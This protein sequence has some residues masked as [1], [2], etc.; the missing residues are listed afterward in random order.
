L[1]NRLSQQAFRKRQNA[2]IKDLERRLQIRGTTD[3]EQIAQLERDNRALREQ[4]TA[5]VNKLE[6][7]QS[8]LRSLSDAM[9]SLVCDQGSRKP[10]LEGELQRPSSPDQKPNCN[11]TYQPVSTTPNITD[12]LGL[13]V[14]HGADLQPQMDD[15]ASLLPTFQL[16]SESGLF[17]EDAGVPL[18]EN[19]WTDVERKWIAQPPRGSSMSVSSPGDCLGRNI[20]SPFTK[21]MDLTSLPGVWTHQYQ[22]G[23]PVFRAHK[24]TLEES[25][26]AFTNSNSSFSDHMS[27]IR[28]CLAKKWQKVSPSQA[29]LA[30]EQATPSPS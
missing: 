4:L 28:G 19:L 10:S 21:L 15:Q 18:A 30:T 13:V 9:N 8:T 11:V 25:K 3:N 1:R 22:M 6:S 16:D 12:A 27:M 5:A 2:H 17:A 14:D 24:R 26:H 7:V 29:Q 20:S 23:P